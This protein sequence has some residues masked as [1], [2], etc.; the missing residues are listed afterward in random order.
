MLGGAWGAADGA[1]GVWRNAEGGGGS[2]VGCEGANDGAGGRG[3]A[4]GVGGRKGAEGM[5]AGAEGTAVGAEGRLDAAGSSL[6]TADSAT[7]DDGGGAAAMVD[8]V[9][10]ASTSELGGASVSGIESIVRR[11]VVGLREAP[12]G[13]ANR[14][15]FLPSG[16]ESW[17]AVSRWS[18]AGSVV[19][20]A[21]SSPTAPS[22]MSDLP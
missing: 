19:A 22:A 11:V 4:D 7:V 16:D 12:S 20:A 15:A 6:S 14:T 2:P 8:L 18:S 17:S 9:D 3:G 1:G 21:S 13:P 5:L 10:A